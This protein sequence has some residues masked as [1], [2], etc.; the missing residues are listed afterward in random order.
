L[1]LRIVHRY[2]SDSKPECRDVDVHCRLAWLWLCDDVLS[3]V[4]SGYR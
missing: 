1:Q 4:L 2:L 3:L